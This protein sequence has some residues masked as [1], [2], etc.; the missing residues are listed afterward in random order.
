MS[1]TKKD[2]SLRLSKTRLIELDT[3]NNNKNNSIR[4]KEVNEMIL[5]KQL[6][7]IHFEV[8]QSHFISNHKD[9]CQMTKIIK[10]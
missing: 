8:Y 2:F 1:H 4:E 6:N 9:C 7:R 3:I 10:Y 5:M